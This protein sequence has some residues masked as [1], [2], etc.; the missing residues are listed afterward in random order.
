MPTTNYGWELPVVGGS[1][2]S[3][4]TILNALAEAIDGQVK[5]VEDKANVAVA[6]LY[7]DFLLSGV[8]GQEAI[9]SGVGVTAQWRSVGAGE[10]LWNQSAG[11]NAHR[12]Y[13]RL[14]NLPVGAVIS[15]IRS[16]GSQ[17]SQETTIALVR[18]AQNGNETVVSAGHVLPGSA[19]ET[20]TTA[21]DH[22]ILAET[23]YYIRVLLTEA[24]TGLVTLKSVGYTIEAAA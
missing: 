23:D 20:E 13:F 24:T 8:A 15:A 4:G 7:G 2:G 1:T 17:V 22:T 14:P 18:V 11:T 9:E 3:W 19:A 12:L 6:A 10:R 5:T 21:I 16:Y